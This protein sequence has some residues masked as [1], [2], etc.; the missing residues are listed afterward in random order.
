VQGRIHIPS[1]LGG[2]EDLL[3]EGDGVL[4][5][6]EDARRGSQMV[7]G[8]AAVEEGVEPEFVPQ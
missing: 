5:N 7:Q 3:G 4:A 6:E 8:S 2:G 1:V